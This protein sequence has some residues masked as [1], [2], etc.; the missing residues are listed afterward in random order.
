MTLDDLVKD[1]ADTI[2]DSVTDAVKHIS[3]KYDK[4]IEELERAFNLK[5]EESIKSVPVSDISHLE[6][7]VDIAIKSIPTPRDGVDGVSPSAEDVAEAMEHIFSKWALEFERKADGIIERAIDRMPKP[8]DGNDGNDGFSIDSFE[9]SL[10]EDSRTV[11]MSFVSDGKTFEKSVY[12][13]LPLDMGSFKHG[14][15]YKKGDGVTYEGSFWIAQKDN[16]EGVP[17]TNG[18]F[19]L[20]VKR[21]RDSKQ[22]IRNAPQEKYKVGS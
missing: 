10:D 13:P 2:K 12:L 16:P 5:L 6:E 3:Q 18:D 21:G 20:A 8:K 1:I 14:T 15:E 17:G 19:R 7:K 11:K 4:K 9:M 22:V